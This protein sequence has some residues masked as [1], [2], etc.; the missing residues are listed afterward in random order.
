MS[1]TARMGTLFGVPMF[2]ETSDPKERESRARA[3][4]RKSPPGPAGGVQAHG[5]REQFRGREG[6]TNTWVEL[7]QVKGCGL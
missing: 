3:A 6:L 5:Q 7:Q 4:A 1:S 2:L